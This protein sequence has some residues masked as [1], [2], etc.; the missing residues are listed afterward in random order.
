MHCLQRAPFRAPESMA[1]I[2]LSAS[3]LTM[4][5]SPAAR[6]GPR[7]TIFSQ[8]PKLMHKPMPSLQRPSHDIAGRPHATLAGCSPIVST[9]K[10]SCTLQRVHGK[11][12]A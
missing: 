11:L 12:A 10:S 9:L 1:E 2:S 3:P 5:A 7:V 8:T 4:Y 6:V